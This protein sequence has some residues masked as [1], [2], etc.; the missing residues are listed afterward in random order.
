M[1]NTNIACA[2]IDCVLG[3]PK[4]NLNKIVSSIRAA[5]ECEAKLVMFPECALTGYAYES[6]A[7]AIPFA[8]QIDGRSSQAIADVCRETNTYA[9]VGFI[10]ADGEK[11]YN[12]AMLV[13]PDGVVGNYRKTHMPFIGIDR[14]LTPGDRA[15]EVFDLPFGKIGVNI[16]YDIS[17]PEPARV[18]KLMGAE[19]IALITNWPA[20]AWRS[21]EFVASARALENHVFYAATDR[22]GTERG[23]KFI[24]RSKVV[25]CNGDSLGEAGVENEELLVAAIDFQEANNNRIVNVAGSYEV[26]RVNDRRPDLYARISEN[27]PV[28]SKASP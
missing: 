2:Q 6:L 27:K 9:V 25:D 15:Y 24:G 21:P 1:A 8:E 14:F 20:A 11:Y 3:D 22:V 4:T 12:A 26:D 10:E 23:W 16:C 17:F 7:E 19:L 13:G 5:A 28:A 18:L